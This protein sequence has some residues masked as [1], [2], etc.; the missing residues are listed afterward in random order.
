MPA[1][2]EL[3][4]CVF[5]LLHVAVDGCIL[6]LLMRWHRFDY[7]SNRKPAPIYVFYRYG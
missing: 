2:L 1:L 5:M 7:T 3:E 6:L 4:V